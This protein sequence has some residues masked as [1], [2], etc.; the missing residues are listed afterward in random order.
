MGG[1]QISVS[2]VD[3]EASLMRQSEVQSDEFAWLYMDYGQDTDGGGGLV[4]GK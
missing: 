1:Q 2:G 4:A 3:T